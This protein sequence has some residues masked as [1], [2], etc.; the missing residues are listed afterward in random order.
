MNSGLH[1]LQV[2]DTHRREKEGCKMKTTN[3]IS[4]EEVCFHLPTPWNWKSESLL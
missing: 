1:L 4:L 2:L 3:P